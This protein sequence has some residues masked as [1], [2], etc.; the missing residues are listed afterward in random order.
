MDIRERI[1]RADPDTPFFLTTPD[2]RDLQ[3]ALEADRNRIEELERALVTKEENAKVADLENMAQA[4]EKD[5]DNQEGSYQEY[6]FDKALAVIERTIVQAY[7]MILFN[8]SESPSRSEYDEDLSN[9]IN[10]MRRIINLEI[11]AVEIKRRKHLLKKV[12]LLRTLVS[13]DKF[14]GNDAA[15]GL[16]FSLSRHTVFKPITAPKDPLNGIGGR[17]CKTSNNGQ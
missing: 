5:K 12:N 11:L 9:S 7:E 3:Q 8:T 14:K 1:R 13:S 17:N 6:L 15:D 2:Q 4:V 10:S 16:A